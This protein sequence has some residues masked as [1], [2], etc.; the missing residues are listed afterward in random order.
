MT[1]DIICPL[2]QAENY[3]QSLHDSL[4]RQKNVKINKIQYILTKSTDNSEGILKETKLNY[5]VIEKKDF[6]HSLVR[7][8]IAMQSTA[9]IICFISQDIVIEN[10]NWL[11]KLVSPIIDKKVDATYSRQLTKFNNTPII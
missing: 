8:N 1:I 7:E 2:Y 6:S 11:E 5:E 10:D 4:L 9:D 3:I